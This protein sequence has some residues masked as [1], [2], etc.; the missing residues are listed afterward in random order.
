MRRILNPSLDFKKQLDT[1]LSNILTIALQRIGKETTVKNY[2]ATAKRDITA[3]T[4]ASAAD[5]LGLM[6][7]A[8]H[9][10][11]EYQNI[12]KTTFRTMSGIH[13]VCSVLYF[14]AYIAYLIISPKG[15]K[16]ALVGVGV[17][18]TFTLIEYRIFDYI[19][20]ALHRR[21]VRKFL[22]SERNKNLRPLRIA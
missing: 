20:F 1:E 4:L 21:R 19:T 14:L 6:V 16:T 13:A 17:Y 22:T 15:V 3:Q 8:Q 11:A 2:L 9:L 7:P 12:S 10:F 18:V 5:E